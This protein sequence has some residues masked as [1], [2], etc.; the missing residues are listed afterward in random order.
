MF[1]VP[2]MKEIRHEWD[3]CFDHDA[4]EWKIGLIAGPSGSGKSTIASEV[5]K[6]AYIH[7]GFDWDR[8]KSV[9]D[10][11]PEKCDVKEITSLMNSVGFSSPPFWLKPFQHLSTGQK[12]RVE[13]ARCIAL[14]EPVV[15]FDEFTSVV[16]RDVAKIGCAAVAKTIRRRQRPQLV[17]VSCHYDIIDW[18]QPDWV[19]DVAANRFEWRSLRRRPEIELKIFHADVS[20]W[21]V[22]KGHHYLTANL[23]KSAKCFV[24]CWN[25]RPVAFTS[26]IHFPHPS[27]KLMKR[28]HRTV[29]L[30][31][32]QGIGIGNAVSEFMAQQVRTMGFRF[33]STSS[34]PSMINHRL[35]SPKWKCIRKAS[36]VARGGNTSKRWNSP[37]VKS[38]SRSRITA[39]FEFIGS[40]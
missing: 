22:F 17:A 27:S 9:L 29:V 16:D 31:D 6:T 37:G 13:L 21:P 38:V 35:K 26:Y 32:Y 30:P 10:G 33:T 20:S 24:A 25:G 7:K 18:L 19:F 11:F 28:E 14:D 8:E 36:H 15:V 1:D 40:K 34:H 12:F 5:F 2:E 39:S 23:S 4:R 3:V